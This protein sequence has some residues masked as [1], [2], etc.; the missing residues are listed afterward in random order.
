MDLNLFTQNVD[1]LNLVLTT[2]DGSQEDVSDLNRAVNSLYQNEYTPKKTQ[3]DTVAVPQAWNQ[4]LDI[5][6]E[7]KYNRDL[8]KALKACDNLRKILGELNPLIVGSAKPNVQNK[9]MQQ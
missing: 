5:I 4:S 6:L 1:A 3:F 7:F 9:R 8:P 2:Y